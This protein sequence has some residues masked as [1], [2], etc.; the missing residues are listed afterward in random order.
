[1]KLSYTSACGRFKAEFEGSTQKEV[2]EKVAEFQEVFEEPA[3]GCC[4]EKNTKL[5]AR[6]NQGNKFYERKCANA[7][8]GAYLAYG[9]N[10]TGGTIFPKRKDEE[11]NRPGPNNGWKKF[12]P[13]SQ[14]PQTNPP[15]T[16]TRR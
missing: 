3:C 8:C 7:A 14:S 15:K 10:K 1:M 12:V 6:E 16:A 5:V 4:G 9:V 13:A 2:F 11:T